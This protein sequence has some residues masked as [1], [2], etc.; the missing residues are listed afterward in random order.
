M[1]NQ[2]KKGFEIMTRKIQVVQHG[3]QLTNDHELNGGRSC[4]ADSKVEWL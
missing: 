3:H 4:S 1:H 2:A